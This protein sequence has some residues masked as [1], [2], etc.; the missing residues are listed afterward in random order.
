M[1]RKLVSLSR[2]LGKYSVSSGSESIL[3]VTSGSLQPPKVDVAIV[4]RLLQTQPQKLFE[5]G[6]K[7]SRDGA[8]NSNCPNQN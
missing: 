5:N 3:V 1:V 4:I 2:L 6:S 7:K 8:K